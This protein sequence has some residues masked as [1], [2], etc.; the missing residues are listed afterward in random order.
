MRI[1]GKKRSKRGMAMVVI[2]SILTILGLLTGLVGKSAGVAL[3]Q[4]QRANEQDQAHFIAY[5]GLQR[6][7]ISLRTDPA[8]GTATGTYLNYPGGSKVKAYVIRNTTGAPKSTGFGIDVPPDTTLVVSRGTASDTERLL[9]ATVRTTTAAS[10]GFG[11]LGGTSLTIKGATIDAFD[12]PGG[13]FTLAGR[14]PVTNSLQVGATD[15]VTR[16][17]DR[18]LT[19]GTTLFANIDGSVASD[20]V[21]GDLDTQEAGVYTL[22][23]NATL[24]GETALDTAA[25][26]DPMPTPTYLGG[27]DV[28]VTGWDSKTLLPGHFNSIHVCDDAKIYLEPG[29]YYIKGNFE[30]WDRAYIKPLGEVRLHFNSA[31]HISNESKVNY[32]RDPRDL[33]IFIT[34]PENGPYPW[35]PWSKN[36]RAVDPYRLYAGA[37]RRGT[38]GSEAKVFAKVRAAESKFHISGYLFGDIQAD[39]LDIGGDADGSGRLSYFAGLGQDGGTAQPVNPANYTYDDIWVVR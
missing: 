5:G 11:M 18:T 30:A 24:A 29:D 3:A 6:V 32:E 2:L 28:D 1:A 35:L 39:K 23:P 16:I 15:G 9:A 13:D 19:D 22:S 33:E 8:W 4:N 17:V 12:A 26:L 31:V 36:R 37:S 27:D 7:L 10:S 20:Q 21:D 34:G 14:T 38:I 25:E